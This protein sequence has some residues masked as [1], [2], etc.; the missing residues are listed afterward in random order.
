MWSLA[1]SLPLLSISFTNG[2][3]CSF[4]RKMPEM[5]TEALSYR[6]MPGFIALAP[7]KFV[8]ENI[9]SCA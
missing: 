6:S 4:C 5:K 9:L 1:L 7:I 2:A 3:G 8:M